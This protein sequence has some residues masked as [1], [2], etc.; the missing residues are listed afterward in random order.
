MSRRLKGQDPLF[1]IHDLSDAEKGQ[2]SIT[3]QE[4]EGTEVNTVNESTQASPATV[5]KKGRRRYHSKSDSQR[6]STWRLQELY[7][8]KDR[9]GK[10]EE[11]SY[12]SIKAFLYEFNSARDAR[13]GLAVKTYLS[14]EVAESLTLRGVNVSKTS[15][16]LKF[17]KSYLKESAETRKEFALTLLKKELKWP[18]ETASPGDQV[19]Q[20]FNL[21][22]LLLQDIPK[23][24]Q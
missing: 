3:D 17:L 10:L 12:P 7:I 22:N 2:L 23:T 21:V 19:E 6:H 1:S 5:R 14:M 16:V 11:I 18:H 20:F 13:P 24:E 15:E 9:V 4:M 8:Q